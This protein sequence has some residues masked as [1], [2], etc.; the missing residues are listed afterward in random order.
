M[1]AKRLR[2]QP[3]GQIIMIVRALGGKRSFWPFN[4]STPFGS[5]ADRRLEMP[6]A[7]EMVCR[8]SVKSL[9]A[10]GFGTGGTNPFVLKMFPATLSQ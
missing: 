2:E 8:V 3:I 10:D 9:A 6:R 7:Y 1:S 5:N 4:H